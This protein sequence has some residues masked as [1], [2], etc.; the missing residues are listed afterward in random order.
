MLEQKSFFKSSRTKDRLV[1][2]PLRVL[3]LFFSSS[4]LTCFAQWG[5]YFLNFP[6]NY[7]LMKFF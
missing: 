4:T 6:T 3:Y 1:F 2:A 7:F 5:N